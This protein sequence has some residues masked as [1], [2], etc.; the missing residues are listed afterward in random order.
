MYVDICE[1]II[2]LS[3]HVKPEDWSNIVIAYEPVWAIGTG[4]TATPD[5]AQEVHDDLRKWFKREDIVEKVGKG[6]A[7]T[8]RILY[9]GKYFSDPEV[10]KLGAQLN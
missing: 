4:V 1:N 7:E 9:G 10:I 5:Q 6:V 8:V 3:D 2:L